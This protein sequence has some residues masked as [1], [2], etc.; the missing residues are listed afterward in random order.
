MQQSQSDR[1]SMLAI[2]QSLFSFSKILNIVLVY[3]N[4]TDR[5][6]YNV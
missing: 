4:K 6:K 2:L 3:Q 5:Y 1:F